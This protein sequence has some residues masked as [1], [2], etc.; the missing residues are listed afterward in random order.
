MCRIICEFRVF[1][2][3]YVIGMYLVLGSRSKHRGY[4]Y[5]RYLNRTSQLRVAVLLSAEK[6]T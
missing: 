6:V 2:C 4:G 5:E 3:G 1:V